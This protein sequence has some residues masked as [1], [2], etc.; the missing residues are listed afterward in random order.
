MAGES[1]PCFGARQVPRAVLDVPPGSRGRLSSLL[2][3]PLAWWPR[4]WRSSRHLWPKAWSQLEHRWRPEAWPPAP[5][6]GRGKGGGRPAWRER[7]RLWGSAGRGRGGRLWHGAC[8]GGPSAWRG[9][10][11]T[12]SSRGTGRGVRGR[13][14]R[15]MQPAWSG[16]RRPW[17]S[18]GRGVGGRLWHGA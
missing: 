6:E 13:G 4:W 10:R 11:R 1:R 3:W 14:S 5:Q 7:R 2:P 18:A 16:G 15:G 8:G 9:N 12:W 17:G